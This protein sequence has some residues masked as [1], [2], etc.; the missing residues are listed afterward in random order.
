[1]ALAISTYIS[2]QKIPDK[3]KK[4]E[5]KEEKKEIKEW[6]ATYTDIYEYHLKKKWSFLSTLVSS[7]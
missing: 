2:L 5:K 7:K 4:N 6:S 3:G 1:M